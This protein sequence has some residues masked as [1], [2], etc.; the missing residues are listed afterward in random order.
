MLT[1]TY[2]VPSSLSL[3]TQSPNMDGQIP[4]SLDVI[5][6]D[7]ELF[8]SL[9]Y[10]E[11]IPT[12]S[13]ASV[14]K[15]LCQ[16]RN[17]Q[18]FLPL[19]SLGHAL[20][21]APSNPLSI[22]VVDKTAEASRQNIGLRLW[23][24]QG[25]E[26]PIGKPEAW[27][28]YSSTSSEDEEQAI[29]GGPELC[30]EQA[31]DG[32]RHDTPFDH[33]SQTSSDK[34]QQDQLDHGRRKRL[35]NAHD[36]GDDARS[37]GA[38]DENSVS[39]ADFLSNKQPQPSGV[40]SERRRDSVSVH[41][42]RRTGHEIP[43]KR[44]AQ[45]DMTPQSA[46]QTSRCDAGH[47][48]ACLTHVPD[49]PASKDKTSSEHV[50]SMYRPRRY[51]EALIRQLWALQLREKDALTELLEDR[52]PPALDTLSKAH[53]Q[54][55]HLATLP[56]GQRYS[57]K[58]FKDL[59]ARSPS[60]QLATLN[61][62]RI[63]NERLTG[64]QK[65]ELWQILR[66][67]AQKECGQRLWSGVQVAPR[68]MRPEHRQMIP[69]ADVMQSRLFTTYRTM[70]DFSRDVDVLAKNAEFFHGRHHAVTIAAERTVEEIHHHMG[71]A[72]AVGKDDAGTEL[73]NGLLR[74]LVIQEGNK[75]PSIHRIPRF[76]LPL[77]QLFLTKDA[78]Q[79]PQQ[80]PAFILLDITDARKAIWLFDAAAT[81]GRCLVMLAEDIALWHL[82]SG[83]DQHDGGLVQKDHHAATRLTE[84]AEEAYGRSRINLL[85]AGTV[86]FAR[87]T[88]NNPALAAAIKQGW[89][90][91]ANSQWDQKTL[92]NRPGAEEEGAAATLT[93]KRAWNCSGA[94]E[95]DE[96]KGRTVPAAAEQPRMPEKKKKNEKKKKT[97]TPSGP[98][99]RTRPPRTV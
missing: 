17:G 38:Q 78:P 48:T 73:Y 77:E 45:T 64:Y 20:A 9:N 62:S 40:A 76:V 46:S 89:G 50:S 3:K 59:Y 69:Q 51:E 92:E 95:V 71:E 14:S 13:D 41:Q 98:S 2:L 58:I 88:K 82:N 6:S 81:S 80:R 55:V 29:Y 60:L 68:H 57:V 11:N 33:D 84:L 22:E 35:P 31:C 53:G 19:V 52:F 93:K 65:V 15:K 91:G 26:V 34:A 90:W 66:S 12:S 79:P 75:L 32:A 8:V 4:P 44:F 56:S 5:E 39:N 30:V 85:R 21:S 27:D 47:S 97:N 74:E 83:P 36:A 86:R 61:D 42:T 25:G 94:G 1:L 70:A 67:V 28:L 23:D 99:R 10:I 63:H 87:A 54:F 72:T 43:G 49:E 24:S 96:E 16:F 37:F 7:G 18:L